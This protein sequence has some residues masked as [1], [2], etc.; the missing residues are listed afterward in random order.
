MFGLRRLSCCLNPDCGEETKLSQ[1]GYCS[2]CTWALSQRITLDAQRVENEI[3]Q[4]AMELLDDELEKAN[5]RVELAQ[6]AARHREQDIIKAAKLEGQI[7][8]ERN[9]KLRAELTKAFRKIRKLEVVI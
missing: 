7:L 3:R 1:A 9:V 4:E 2:A 8:L 5:I 6:V